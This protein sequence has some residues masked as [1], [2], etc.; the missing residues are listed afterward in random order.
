MIYLILYVFFGSLLGPP[1]EPDGTLDKKHPVRNENANLN[2]SKT[3]QA[4]KSL[5]KN[6]DETD[7]AFETPISPDL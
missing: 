5:D 2:V 7:V 1:I 6:D 4:K 3:S